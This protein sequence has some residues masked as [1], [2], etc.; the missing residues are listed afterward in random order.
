[1]SA[2]QSIYI[3][4]PVEKVFDFCADPR[5]SWSTGSGQLNNELLDVRMT[6][7]GVGTY[8]S[9]AMK[10]AGLRMEGFD[11]YTEFVRNERITDRSSAAMAGTWTYEF[12]PEGPGTRLTVQR[13]PASFWALRPVDRLADR[14]F[15]A[16]NT[17]KMLEAVKAQMEKPTAA[18]AVPE[19]RASAAPAD[20]RTARR[21]SAQRI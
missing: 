21:R 3:D 20:R 9:W 2:K 12:E 13:H 16:P 1:M 7:E 17:R 14:L 8:Y 4:A 5:A 19:Q 15:V 10:L 6:K 11:V 18:A